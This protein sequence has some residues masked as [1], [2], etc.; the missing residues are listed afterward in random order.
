MNPSNSYQ[1]R[2]N[3]FAE[4]WQTL[5]A[6]T[7]GC[8]LCMATLASVSLGSFIKPLE[9]AMGWSRT[10]VQGAL[11]FGQGFGSLGI[12]LTGWLLE[13]FSTRVIAAVSL[14]GNATA[15]AAVSQADSLSLFYLCYAFAAFI[16]AGAGFITWSRAITQTF[17]I[18]RGFALAIALSG[19]GLASIF[20]PPFLAAVI[21]SY[22]W[23]AGFL[24]L[25]SMQ[26]LIA[27]PAILICMRS[28]D[29]VAGGKRPPSKAE[30]VS[31]SEIL[32]QRRF[33]IIMISVFCVYAGVTGMLPNFI[34][35]LSDSGFSPQAAATAQG[36]AGIGLLVG[37]LTLGWLID[38][39]WAPAVGAIY[40][41][42]AAI[43]SIILANDPSF[44]LAVT[45]IALF[46]VASGAELD[47]MAYL[48]S[49][50]FREA[51]F[52]R[53]YSILY[54][55]L[56]VAGA[57]APIAMSYLADITGSFVAS[58]YLCAA[59]FPLGGLVLLLLGPYPSKFEGPV[60]DSA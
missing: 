46:G 7:I 3:E 21:S 23:H 5:L 10:E 26:G 49:R 25:A 19:T 27:L 18:K 30:Y 43:G 60:R 33:W 31:W 51:A 36:A 20:V 22:G 53:A 11:I 38:K 12:L 47:L 14:L 42:P 58:L 13:R 32:I 29:R 37:R 6:G 34:P 1:R 24:A 39:F 45:A 8:A 16:G 41:I 52:P 15:F 4:N 57:T 44:E 54:I 17:E 56:A 55:P 59:L 28:S 50:Y 35:L 40:I 48:L 9:E 2:P